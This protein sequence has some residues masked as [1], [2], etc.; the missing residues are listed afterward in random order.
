M[1]KTFPNHSFIS[2]YGG[3]EFVVLIELKDK[4]D[5]EKSLTRLRENI[6]QFNNKKMIPY[7]INLSI[8][9]DLYNQITKMSGQEFLCHID[10][11]MYQDKQTLT[12]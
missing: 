8:G 6:K 7:E 9:A 4:S 2:R 12:A 1:K 10:S 3:D 5:L 11:L